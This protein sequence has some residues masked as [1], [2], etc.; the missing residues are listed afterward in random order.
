MNWIFEMWNW[1]IAGP[2]IGLFVPAL[3][4]VTNKM[5]G[6]SS[7]FEH[8]CM[9]LLPNE[10]RSIFNFNWKDSGW[11][12]YFVV[13]IMIGAYIATKFLSSSDIHFLPA[14][15]YSWSGYLT[16]FIGGILVGFGTRYA[17]GCTSGHSIFGLSILS[18]ASLKATIS[19]FIGG[20]IYT[21]FA[22][23]V[24]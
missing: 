16:L 13:G 8:L 20:L 3:L 23:V 10:K 6:I 24:M 11:K 15:Y 21:F 19:F 22:H 1:Y 17:N 12:I 7:S 9:M 18:S 5:L 2:L 14:Q 4:I